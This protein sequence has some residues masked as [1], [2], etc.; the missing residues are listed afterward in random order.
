MKLTVRRLAAALLCLALAVSLGGCSELRAF[1]KTFEKQTGVALPK[2]CAV[3]EY[4]DDHGGFHGDGTLLAVVTL[5]D[6]EA[7][8][9]FA[10]RLISAGWSG[11]LSDGLRAALYGGELDGYTT[12]GYFSDLK[13][14]IPETNGL[15]FYL[16]RYMQQYG[17]RCEFAPYTQNF[18]FSLYVPDTL[19]LYFAEGDA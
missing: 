5:P 17:E 2:G 19:T 9:L 16:D 11:S 8:A 13:L 3:T 1:S 4:R 7:G 15:C 18:T 14:D 12:N 10:G 6:A